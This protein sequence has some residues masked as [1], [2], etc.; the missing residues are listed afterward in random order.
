M[1]LTQ[2]NNLRILRGEPIHHNEDNTTLR[3]MMIFDLFYV[4]G[5]GIVLS[6]VSTHRKFIDF[7][8]SNIGGTCNLSIY[9]HPLA[10][11]YV[12]YH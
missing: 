12:F 11:N 9:N 5:V 6:L 10:I 7:I 8:I 3:R 2:L 4:Y 1:K